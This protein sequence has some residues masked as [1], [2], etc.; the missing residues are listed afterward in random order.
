MSNYPDDYR[1]QLHPS[2]AQLAEEQKADERATEDSSLIYRLAAI[3]ESIET[4]LKD[5]KRNRKET[6]WTKYGNGGDINAHFR[7]SIKKRLELARHLL[8]YISHSTIEKI[9]TEAV[10]HWEQQDIDLDDYSPE[11]FGRAKMMELSTEIMGGE[12]DYAED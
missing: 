9:T 4:E 6:Y 3:F 1:D 7:E 12:Y 5:L 2:D 8:G 11:D 10:E